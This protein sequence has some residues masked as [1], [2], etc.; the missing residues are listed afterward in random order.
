MDTVAILEREMRTMGIAGAIDVA[1]I[2]ARF[3]DLVRKWNKV[4]NLTKILSDERMV[5]EH[6]LDSLSVLPLIRGPNVLDVGTGAGFPG[7]P[8]AVAEPTMNVTLL[9]SSQKRCA[10]LRQAAIDL[11]LRNVDIAC[12]RVE[13][14]RPARPY[15]TVVSRAFAE[16][17]DFAA[18][19]SGLIH[20]HGILVAMKGVYP[21]EEIARIPSSV[22]VRE[23]VRLQ[24]A[25]LD[26]QRH[27]VIM[28][29]AST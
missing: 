26:A 19:A 15:D 5:V 18:A 1:G 9:D 14:F 17:A 25:G 24:V 11:G 13:Q 23:V 16:C 8:L 21:T 2:L 22:R 10:F 6:V 12:A 28:T 29:K 7:I 3:L 4:Y 20:D 27:A